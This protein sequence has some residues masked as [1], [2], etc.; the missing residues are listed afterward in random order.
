MKDNTGLQVPPLNIAMANSVMPKIAAMCRWLQVAGAIAVSVGISLTL[1]HHSSP[2]KIVMA[3]L[4]LSPM[5]TIFFV[6]VNRVFLDL[7]MVALFRGRGIDME[8][9]YESRIPVGLG[10]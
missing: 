9:E 2:A 3:V 1:F 4:I 6:I 8:E 7:V 10:R 5:L